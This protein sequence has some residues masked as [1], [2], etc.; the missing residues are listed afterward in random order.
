MVFS[1]RKTM[2]RIVANDRSYWITNAPKL[3]FRFAPREL[4]FDT[5]I[6]MFLVLYMRYVGFRNL[7]ILIITPLQRSYRFTRALKQRA[8]HTQ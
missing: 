3:H 7:F 6:Q 4:K 8:E 5:N 2:N 1:V